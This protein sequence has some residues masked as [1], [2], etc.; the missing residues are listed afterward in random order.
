[1][2]THICIYSSVLDLDKRSNAHVFSLSSLILEQTSISRLR[3]KNTKKNKKFFLVLMQT[4]NKTKIPLPADST[5]RLYTHKESHRQSQLTIQKP[6]VNYYYYYH[7]AHTHIYTVVCVD[8]LNN[9]RHGLDG[10]P[11]SVFLIFYFFFCVGD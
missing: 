11:K 4:G 7:Q 5:S 10:R 6:V 1:M 3:N 8:I 9:A 2:H